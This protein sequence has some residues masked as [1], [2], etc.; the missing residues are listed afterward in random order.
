MGAPETPPPPPPLPTRRV[1]EPQA[2]LAEAPPLADAVQ[3][4]GKALEG[5][6]DDVGVHAVPAGRAGGE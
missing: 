5:G 1:Q 3:L 4:R 6:V 2:D